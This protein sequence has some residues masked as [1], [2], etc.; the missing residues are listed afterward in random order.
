MKTYYA[1]SLE[2]QPPEK[3]QKLEDHL[4]NVEEMAAGFA[5]QLLGCGSMLFSVTDKRLFTVRG[6][7][8]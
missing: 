8:S 4:R 3:W 1:H 2:D 6:G 7:V 5:L